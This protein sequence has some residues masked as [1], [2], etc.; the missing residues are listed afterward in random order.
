MSCR[1]CHVLEKKIIALFKINYELHCGMEYFKGD[2]F[3]MIKD[4]CRLILEEKEPVIFEEKNPIIL[5]EK[6]PVILEEKNPVILEE[7]EP[8]IFEE[9]VVI[10]EIGNTDDE[11]VEN[12]E[13]S[14]S[15]VGATTLKPYFCTPCGYPCNR[16]SNLIKHQATKKH[17]DKIQNKVVVEIGEYKCKNCVRTYNSN[18]GLWAHNKKCK[19]AVVAVAVAVA[20]PKTDLREEINSLKVMIIEMIRNQ[21]TTK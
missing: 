5:E 1:D 16:K 21:Q 19:P 6:N 9:K 7:K 15:I 14:S 13:G 4:I 10:D 8:V 12:D 2:R 20:V 3:E 11:K 18:Q 17:L